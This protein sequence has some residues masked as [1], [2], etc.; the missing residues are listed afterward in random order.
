MF[1][2]S[3]SSTW[4]IFKVAKSILISIRITLRSFRIQ[5]LHRSLSG[6]TDILLNG[7]IDELLYNSVSFA[8]SF[9]NITVS[10]VYSASFPWTLDIF[11][12]NR[13]KTLWKRNK[14]YVWFGINCKQKKTVFRHLHCL[15]NKQTCS[16]RFTINC[17]YY[18]FQ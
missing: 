3:I 1:A 13:A 11:I 14:E 10:V 5:R 4:T 7:F 9:C 2:G 18:Y 8:Q 16:V 6:I 17:Y 15:W 12:F